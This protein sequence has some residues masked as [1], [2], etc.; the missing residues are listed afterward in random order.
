MSSIASYGGGL[1]FGSAVSIVQIPNSNA[2]QVTSFFGVSGSLT[3]YGGGRGRLFLVAGV[4]TAASIPDLNATESLLLSYADGVARTLID[5]RGRAWLNVIFRG[6]FRPDP[7]GARPTDQG[8]CLPYKLVLHG[9][10]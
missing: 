10:S 6:E 2:Q 9:L 3:L 7:R 1:I 8:W 5:T 4:L